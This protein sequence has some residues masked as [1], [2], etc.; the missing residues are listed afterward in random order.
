M[1]LTIA[2]F[3]TFTTFASGQSF[4]TAGSIERILIT[5]KLAGGSICNNLYA[6]FHHQIKPQLMDYRNG[7]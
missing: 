2:F 3:T 1:S 7:N 4:G 5:E 6:K